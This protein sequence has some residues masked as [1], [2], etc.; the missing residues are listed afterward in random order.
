MG[1]YGDSIGIVTA[2]FWAAGTP[3][4]S[5]HDIWKIHRE[6]LSAEVRCSREI[7]GRFIGFGVVEMRCDEV[8]DG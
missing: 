8:G 2:R 5:V 1:V 3:Q 6:H 4:R 7:S